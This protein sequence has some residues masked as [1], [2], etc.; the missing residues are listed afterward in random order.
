[1]LRRRNPSEREAIE[2]NDLAQQALA[3]IG[4]LQ[5]RMWGRSLVC[6]VDTPESYFNR[7]LPR[8][9]VRGAALGFV[10]N[11]WAK[12]IFVG[13]IC[14]PLQVIG[15]EVANKVLQNFMNDLTGAFILLDVLLVL[16]VAY[17]ATKGANAGRR[18]RAQYRERS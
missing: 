14:V 13:F 11:Q 9:G 1:M 15:A 8:R 2:A 6:A 10:A 16:V 4:S 7:F 12:L 17:F 3:S 18:W 5:R